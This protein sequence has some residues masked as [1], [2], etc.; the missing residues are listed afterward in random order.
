MAGKNLLNCNTRPARGGEFER[1][2]LVLK[3]WSKKQ[4]FAGCY[5]RSA[6]LVA[7]IFAVAC[8]CLQAPAQA[9]PGDLY[10][11][12]LSDEAI[13]QFTPQGGHTT[14]VSGIFADALVF[15]KNG[16]L[17]VSDRERDVIVKITRDGTQSI[18]ASGLLPGPLTFDGTG[19]LFAG[20]SATGSIFKFDP[21]GVRTV[22]ATGLEDPLGLAFDFSG[23]LLVTDAHSVL[24]FTP[25]GIRTQFA[26]NLN[27]PTGIALSQQGDIF[28]LDYGA[29][30]ILRFTSGGSA[31]LFASSLNGPRHVALDSSGNLY[32]ATF[33]SQEIIKLTP[34]GAKTIFASQTN[35]GGLAFEP[36]PLSL[37]SI[38]SIRRVTGGISIQGIGSPST[39]YR[40]E[41]ADSP[42]PNTFTLLGLTTT[43]AQGAFS[44]QDTVNPPPPA[45]RF[46]RLTLLASS[47][48]SSAIY[49]SAIR[50]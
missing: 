31:T 34:D 1:F 27:L 13:I 24:K 21:N 39:Q 30:S 33:G 49:R 5:R 35:A 20:D 14:F 9:A 4:N 38:T 16:D 48:Q 23:N 3:A 22:F 17:F 44:Y 46:Y 37:A 25:A 41:Y 19:N 50:R 11:G 40:V 6:L 45:R 8:A 28:V 32:V 47:N 26:S 10:H 7:S 42:Q 2:I 12:V 36:Q 43:D 29:S 18:F 15:G